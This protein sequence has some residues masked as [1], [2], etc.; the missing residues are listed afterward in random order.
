M[1][2]IILKWVIA[3]LLPFVGVLISGRPIQ[4]VLNA[5]VFCIN[6]WVAL[7]WAFIILISDLPGNIENARLMG[8]IN[9]QTEL[10]SKL[11]AED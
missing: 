3:I 9:R 5:V 7:G 4:A 8:Q 10:L 2:R 6:P 1:W 11:A